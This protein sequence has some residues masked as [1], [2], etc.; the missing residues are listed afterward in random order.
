MTRSMAKMPTI[1]DLQ[2]IDM[3]ASVAPV[4]PSFREIELQKENDFLH[5]RL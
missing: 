3:S 5:M 4:N 1:G 2:S